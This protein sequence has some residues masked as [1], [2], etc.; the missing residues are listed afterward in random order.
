MGVYFFWTGW[1]QQIMPPVPPL[2][3]MNCEPHTV[4][5][6]R[7]PVSLATFLPSGEEIYGAGAYYREDA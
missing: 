6:Y 7:F 3:T 2:V 5:L 4:Q 1:P